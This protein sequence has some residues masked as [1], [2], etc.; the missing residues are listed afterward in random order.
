MARRKRYSTKNKN[1]NNNHL[2]VKNVINIHE[3]KTRKRKSRSK[4]DPQPKPG[5]SSINVQ[6]SHP[7]IQN[8]YNQPKGYDLQPFASREPTTASSELVRPHV[9]FASATGSETHRSEIPTASPLFG[10]EPNIPT[11]VF[12]HPRSIK[13]SVSRIGPII[14][15]PDDSDDSNN[16][17]NINRFR[18]KAQPINDNDQMISDMFFNNYKPSGD[19]IY[20][21]ENKKGFDDDKKEEHKADFNDPHVND[22]SQPTTGTQSSGYMTRAKAKSLAKEKLEDITNIHTDLNNIN[23]KD[24]L[25]SMCDIVGIDKKTVGKLSTKQ[26][27]TKIKNELLKNT[28]LIPLVKKSVKEKIK[29]ITLPT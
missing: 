18:R 17:L 19:S 7:P 8:V 20:N 11:A 23:S 3:K 22:T 25:K 9:S 27:S 2:T 28:E 15:E 12:T 6:V 13:R 24:F 26:L 14:E 4:S 10:S 21:N 1:T 16:T 5:V 29:S